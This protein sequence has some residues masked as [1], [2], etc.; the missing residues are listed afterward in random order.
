[1]EFILW[2]S[3]VLIIYC[4]FG[5]PFL[6]FFVAKFF[7]R[8]VA[9]KKFSPTVSIV[10]SVYDEEDF[11]KQKMENLLAV[12]YP[13]DKIE[14]LV[15]SDGSMDKTNE[16]IKS[17]DDPRIHFIEKHERNGKMMV[18]NQLVKAAKNEI[19]VGT[20]ARQNFARDAVKELVA[21]FSDPKVGCVSGE[22]LLSSKEGGTAKG[23]NLYWNYEKFIRGQESQVHSMLGATG[24]IYAF[25]RELFT[26]IPKDVVLDDMFVPLKIIQKGFRAIF[27]DDA[28]AYDEV[29]DSPR[30]EHRRKARTL[31]GNYQIFQIFFTM[32]NPSRSPIAIQLF[33]HKFLRTIIPFLMI[34]V[35]FI[36]GALIGASFYGVLFVVQIIFYGMAGVGVLA[37]HNKYVILAPI[38]RI[39]YI[40]YV[41]CLLNFSALSGF[42]RFIGSKQEITWEKAKKSPPNK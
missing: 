13:P 15:G 29:A 26:E 42:L 41:F 34:F 18:V 35:F 5:Y 11:I 10:L 31:Y 1:M 24:A 21:N 36:N 33:S 4:Y 32:F 23:I 2:T 27:D 37:R 19:I 17:F 38:S 12:D 6:I 7:K 39:C 40:P 22:L 8:S 30:E 16:I 14:F 3:I 28:K 25:R 9:K 20:D